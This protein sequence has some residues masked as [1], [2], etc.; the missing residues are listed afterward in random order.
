MTPQTKVRPICLPEQ[1][2]DFDNLNA[3]SIG[4][5]MTGVRDFNVDIKIFIYTKTN[6]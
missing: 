6:T 3:Y 4:W 5:G 2:Q 1:G